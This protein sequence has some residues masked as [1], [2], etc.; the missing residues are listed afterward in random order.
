MLTLLNA[1]SFKMQALAY[2]GAKRKA[3][4]ATRTPTGHIARHLRPDVPA[5]FDRPVFRTRTEVRSA[6]LELLARRADAN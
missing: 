6:I 2:V 5:F 3:E 1:F 4:I